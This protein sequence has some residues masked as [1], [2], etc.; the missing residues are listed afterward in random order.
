MPFW[1]SVGAGFVDIMKSLNRE[2]ALFYLQLLKKP[3]KP[4]LTGNSFFND[5]W[6]L[7]KFIVEQLLTG[8]AKWNS[9]I[10]VYYRVISGLKQMPNG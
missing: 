3:T 10:I 1:H 4:A 6:I 9:K 5:Y 8:G 2:K 7:K